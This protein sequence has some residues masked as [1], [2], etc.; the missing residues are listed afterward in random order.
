LLGRFLL[1]ALGLLLLMVV[2]GGT[3]K[4]HERWIQPF[5]LFVPLYFFGRLRGV[6]LPAGR[7]RRLAW[8]VVLFAGA[9]TGVRAGATA[10]ADLD[11]SDWPLRCRFGEAA[12]RLRGE[13]GGAVT[14]VGVD[15]DVAGKLR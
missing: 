14:V 2:V 10:A 4:F 6:E 12:A 5:T 13:F 15:R 1:A 11:R 3:T 9:L 8:L 7:L